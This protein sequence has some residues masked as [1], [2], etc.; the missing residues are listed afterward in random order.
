M[1]VSLILF[2]NLF[3]SIPTLCSLYYY[4][5]TVLI[6]VGDNNNSENSLTVQDCFG[7][8]GFFIYLSIFR[9]LNFLSHRSFTCLLR[10]TLKY[11]YYLW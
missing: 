6:E 8:P 11:L 10:V 3:D 9:N 7:Y 5:S 4:C 1:G 2:N